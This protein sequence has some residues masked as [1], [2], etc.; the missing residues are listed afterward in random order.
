[1]HTQ[2]KRQ[3]LMEA[4]SFPGLVRWP[5]L[6]IVLTPSFLIFFSCQEE[7]VLGGDLG[8]PRRSGCQHAAP[9]FCSRWLSSR[10]CPAGGHLLTTSQHLAQ[11]GLGAVGTP[12]P[13]AACLPRQLR[14][15]TFTLGCRPC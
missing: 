7:T 5:H 10:A 11:G 6:L 1:M 14:V 4:L 13:H 8:P 2:R 9:P 15:W 3:Q 12:D